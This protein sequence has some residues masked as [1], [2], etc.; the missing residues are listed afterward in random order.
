MQHPR[1]QKLTKPRLTT[2]ESMTA[3]AEL[4]VG[5]YNSNT[6]RADSMVKILVAMGGDT[7]M[8]RRYR[9][10]EMQVILN[11]MRSAC[12]EIE[13]LTRMMTLMSG[14]DR[15]E[16]LHVIESVSRKMNVEGFKP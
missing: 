8:N 13:I 12:D 1:T 5:I 11:E 16:V 6:S 10:E 3:T 14:N 15:S 7:N 4:Q 9:V 2:L